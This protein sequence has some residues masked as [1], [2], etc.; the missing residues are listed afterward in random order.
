MKY[1]SITAIITAIQN[2]NLSPKSKECYISKIKVLH[3][4]LSSDATV[5]WLKDAISVINLIEARYNSIDSS[6][7]ALNIQIQET[8]NCF[9][10]PDEQVSYKSYG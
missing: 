1:Q 2:D 4:Q 7:Q 6:N 9:L 10:C 5:S 3:Q 8:E